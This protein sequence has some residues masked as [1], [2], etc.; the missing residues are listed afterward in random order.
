MMT[1]F[2][3]MWGDVAGDTTHL[4]LYLL[5]MYATDVGNQDTL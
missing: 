2:S 4:D 3:D 1:Y 5:I